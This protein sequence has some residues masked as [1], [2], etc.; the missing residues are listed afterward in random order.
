MRITLLFTASIVL[1]IVGAIIKVLHTSRL[2]TILL[3]M[4]FLGLVLSL[5]FYLARKKATR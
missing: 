3:A 4:S 2:S 1:G 5:V